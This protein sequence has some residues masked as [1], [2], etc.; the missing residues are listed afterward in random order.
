MHVVGDDAHNWDQMCPLQVDDNEIGL[1]A[2]YERTAVGNPN[3][4]ITVDGCPAVDV[5]WGGLAA[6]LAPHAF[7]EQSRTQHLDHILCHVVG[8]HGDPATI[9]FEVGDARAQATSS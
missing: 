5:L 2:G 4:A 6:V 8:A 9:G 3:R 7:H 1:V